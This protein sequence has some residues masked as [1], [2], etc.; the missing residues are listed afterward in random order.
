MEKNSWTNLCEK[1][2]KGILHTVKRRK[3]NCIGY[4][5]R[6]NC[7]LKHVTK[8]TIDERRKVTGRRRKLRKQLLG[9]KEKRG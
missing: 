4:I 8:E 2:T 6:M 1:K 5:L 3:A 7:F 9:D